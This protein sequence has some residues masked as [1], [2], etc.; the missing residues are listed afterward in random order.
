M[1]RRYEDTDQEAVLSVWDGAASLAHPFLSPDFQR[2]ERSNIARQYLPTASTLVYES[3]G[4]VVGFISMIETE[5]GGLFVEPERHR[6]GIATALVDAACADLNTVDVEVFAGNVLGRR[7]C[8]ARGFSLISS[9]RHQET[10]ETV[11]H[12]RRHRPA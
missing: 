9:H 4:L 3:D 7:F 1:I 12:L 10:G 8:Q 2:E 5:I 11:L 6:Q